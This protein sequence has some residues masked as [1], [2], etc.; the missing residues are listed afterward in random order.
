M[1]G[2]R[3]RIRVWRTSLEAYNHYCIWQQWKGFK[4]FMFWACFSYEEKGPCHVWEDK[5]EKE[6]EKAKK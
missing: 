2:Q 3:G 6:K 5:I 4:Q 1:G